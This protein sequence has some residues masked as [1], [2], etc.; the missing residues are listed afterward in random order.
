LFL[1][2]FGVVGMRGIFEV[3][4]CRTVSALGS[5]VSPPRRSSPDNSRPQSKS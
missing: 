2:D 1:T 4:V 3:G 5:E